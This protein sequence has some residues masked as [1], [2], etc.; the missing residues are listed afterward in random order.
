MC[1]SARWPSTV[2]PPGRHNRLAFAASRN[3]SATNRRDL[4]L[5]QIARRAFLALSRASF[6]GARVASH[7][8]NRGSSPLGSANQLKHLYR[9]VDHLFCISPTF[10]QKPHR[11]SS[12][13]CGATSRE[14]AI[15]IPARVRALGAPIFQKWCV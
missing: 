11:A 2:E 4:V 7:G 1:N 14:K 3:R 5:T 9:N 10:L 8:E 12:Q 13:R 15:A 6:F